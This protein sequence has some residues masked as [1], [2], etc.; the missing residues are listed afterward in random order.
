MTKKKKKPKKPYPLFP[1][2]AHPNGQSCKK[3]RGQV[4]FF[5]VWSDTEAALDRYPA[6]AADLHAGRVPPRVATD[7]VTIKE[8]CN[9][10][11][12][13]QKARLDA[14]GIGPWWFE[15]CRRDSIDWWALPTL[16]TGGH[17]CHTRYG[18]IVC[19]I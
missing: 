3:I 15:D 1:L 4:R 18:G 14:G 9:A 12:G 10:C 7:G 8:A 11:P 2:T 16:L 17:R 5:G 19:D 13:W 6:E